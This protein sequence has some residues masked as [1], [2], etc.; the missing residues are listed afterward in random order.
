MN[1]EYKELSLTGFEVK[2]DGESNVFEGY[3]STFGNTDSVGD[4]IEKGAFVKSIATRM[5][6]ML[7]QHRMDKPIGVYTEIREDGQ[8]LYVKGKIANTALGNEAAELARMG[9]I[10]SMSIGFS[11]A[12][13]GA[14]YDRAKDLRIIKEVNLF[15][16]SL[17]TFPANEMAK[18]TSAKNELPRTEREFEQFLRDAGFS[19]KLAK[20][21]TL[22]G[23]KDAENSQRD[24]GLE[25]E[26][27]EALAKLQHTFNSILKG[28]KS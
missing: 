8:G 18:I 25:A 24:A 22:E 3:A 16:I 26:N 28:L 13:G 7:W 11:I 15:E 4:V 5:P 23:F 10:D 6:K 20:G 21:I 17:V 2:K 19:R 1:M 14:T 12:K 9:A 27:S